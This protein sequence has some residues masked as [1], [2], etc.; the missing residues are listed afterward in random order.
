[1]NIADWKKP[2]PLPAGKFSRNVTPFKFGDVLHRKIF[3]KLNREGNG[4]NARVKTHRDSRGVIWNGLP[5]YW[6]SK[7]HYRGGCIGQRKPLHWQVWEHA[8]KKSVP[9]V[10]R[11]VVVFLNGNKHDFTPAN[12][13][14]KTRGQ[15]GLLN[16]RGTTEERRDR[17]IKLWRKIPAEERSRL[18]FERWS[19][20]SRRLVNSMLKPN[21][22][23]TN[24]R[25]TK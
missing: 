20:R 5:F 8:N 13:A 9:A 25:R 24:L 2:Q 16:Q 23:L 4:M 7:G 17:M 11:H 22:Q 1:M 6:S 15:I 3:K 12:L 10:P 19:R 21:G 18:A 14:I